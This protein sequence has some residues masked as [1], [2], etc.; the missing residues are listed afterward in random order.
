MENQKT[1]SENTKT[2]SIKFTLTLLQ[3]KY[4]KTPTATTTIRYIN[5]TDKKT[6]T[7][8]KTALEKLTRNT[9]ITEEKLY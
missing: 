3:L 4:K 9:T 6:T 1:F 8:R 7:I 2:R 5:N